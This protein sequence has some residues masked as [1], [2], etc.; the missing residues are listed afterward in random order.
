M[1]KK[2]LRLSCKLELCQKP[3][4]RSDLRRIAKGRCKRGEVG[5]EG[6]QQGTKGNTA[7]EGHKD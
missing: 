7:S 4:H 2:W 3:F 1:L 6:K 5:E